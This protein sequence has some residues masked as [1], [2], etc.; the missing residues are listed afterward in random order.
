[1]PDAPST[2]VY[3][4]WGVFLVTWAIAALFTKRT[5]ERTWGTSR[6]L[7][8]GTGLVVYWIARGFRLFG[9]QRLWTSTAEIEWLAAGITLVGLGV[10]L[11]ARWALGRNWSGSVTFKQDHELIEHGPYR[12]VRH[13]IY[14]G[15]LT[16]ALG[17]AILRDAV[18]GFVFCGILLA[19]FWIKL[20]AEEQLMTRH[21]PDAY[22]AYRERVRALIPF[23]L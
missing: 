13:P 10:T 4:C 2:V 9:T 12:F 6:W 23:V 18:S 15:L 8:I 7:M 1:M 21:F 22:P 16:M 20:R 3:A 17:S 19:G 5:L 14:T 11:W